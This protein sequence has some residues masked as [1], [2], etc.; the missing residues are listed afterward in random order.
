LKT[1]APA[2]K[3][4]RKTKELLGLSDDDG[5]DE[6]KGDGVGKKGAESKSA[7]NRGTKNGKGGDEFEGPKT[8]PV[9]SKRQIKRK[10]GAAGGGDKA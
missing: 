7:V 6:R 9:R 1:K 10:T 4:P 5:E 3:R 8:P 2:K